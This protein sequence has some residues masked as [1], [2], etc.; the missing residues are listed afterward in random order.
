K[1]M[2][3]G[4]SN[5]C[6]EPGHTTGRHYTQ[7]QLPVSSDAGVIFRDKTTKSARR[8]YLNVI[9]RPVV[10][11]LRVTPFATTAQISFRQVV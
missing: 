10:S 4:A 1:N 3:A 7:Q 5:A 8:P 11:P 6:D 9:K 2:H